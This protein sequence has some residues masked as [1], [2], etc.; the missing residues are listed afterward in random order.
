ML[1]SRTER[2]E[3]MTKVLENI[4]RAR[5]KRTEAQ[6]AFLEALRKGRE[7]GHSWRELAEPAGLTPQGVRWY[8]SDRRRNDGS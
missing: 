7:S 3:A 8:L 1:V 4:A 2:G 5:I 6:A